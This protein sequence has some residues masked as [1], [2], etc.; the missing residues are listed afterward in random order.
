MTTYIRHQTSLKI[1]VKEL[2]RVIENIHNIYKPKIIT[3]VGDVN[4]DIFNPPQR[5]KNFVKNNSL[6]TTITT[7]TRYDQVHKTKKSID[8]ILTNANMAVSAGT[9][10]QISDHLG[11]YTIF[12]KISK[13][14]HKTNKILSKNRYE[15][16]KDKM[17]ESI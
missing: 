6:R 10:M 12:R 7:Y 2:E 3:L 11:T 9:L 5:W 8:T 16:I 17:I 14:T 4:I 15:R 1:V 13:L